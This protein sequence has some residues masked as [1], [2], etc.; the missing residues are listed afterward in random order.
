MNRQKF[1]L[2]VPVSGG[3]GITLCGFRIPR[4]GCRPLILHP[5]FSQSGNVWDLIPGRISLADYLWSK[6]FDIWIIHQRGTGGSG[7]AHVHNSLDELAAR[8]IPYVIDYVSRR[9]MLRPIFVGHSEGGIAAILSMLGVAI[10]PNGTSWLSDD[11]CR[12]RQ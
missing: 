5:G 1:Y 2:A 4:P 6:G 9:T 3:G 12:A 8:D 10:T 7:G 11:Q